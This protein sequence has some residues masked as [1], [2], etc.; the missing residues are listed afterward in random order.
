MWGPPK[1]L[2]SHSQTLPN[3]PNQPHPPPMHVQKENRTATL[4]E[5]APGLIWH[6][7]K[8][9]PPLNFTLEICYCFPTLDVGALLSTQCNP[10]SLI[11]F[12][13]LSIYIDIFHLL[14]PPLND[15]QGEPHR[16]VAQGSPIGLSIGRAEP[17]RGFFEPSPQHLLGTWA[18]QSPPRPTLPMSEP[19][20]C[21]LGLGLGPR[22]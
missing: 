9:Y 5:L 4:L 8:Q 22:A 20:P 7:S 21:R 12:H 18:G 17:G 19:S 11:F 16:V 15:H 10:I 6:S 14:P 1:R 13:H 2:R 3:H